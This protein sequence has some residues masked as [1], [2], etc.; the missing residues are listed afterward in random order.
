MAQIGS[1][2][3]TFTASV[4]GLTAGV[5]AAGK[6]FKAL[7]GD[8]AT[9]RSSLSALSNLGKQGFLEVGP[10]A[11][12]ASAAFAQI[13]GDVARLRAEFVSG[14]ISAGQFA[15][16]MTALTA[17]AK[18]MATATA[19]AAAITRENATATQTYLAAIDRITNAVKNGGLAEDVAARAR[20][21]ALDTFMGAAESADVET[22]A[23]DRLNASLGRLGDTAAENPFAGISEAFAAAIE[24]SDAINAATKDVEASLA[25]QAA[26]SEAAAI[27]E[28]IRQEQL[29]RGAEIAA[30]VASATQLHADALDEL[31]VLQNAGA[32]SAEVYAAAVARQNEILAE[33]DGSAQAARNAADELADAHQR[34]AAVTRANM[35][36]QERYAAEV[37]DLNALLRVGAI[38][39][40]TYNRAVSEAAGRMRTAGSAAETMS[41]GLS[42][43]SSRLNVLIGL[44]V[45]RI[46]ASIATSVSNAV[47]SLVRM[48]QAEAGVIDQTSKLAAR[49]GI[50]YG[51]MAGLSLAAE[52]AG[53]GVES[54]RDAMTKADVTF[55]NAANGSQQA[56]QAF[57]RIGLSAQQ[58]N[59][60]NTAD[61]FQAIA[62][63]IAALPTE[64][65]RA[66]AAVQIFGRSGADLLPLFEG[67]AQGIAAARREAEQLGLALTTA[68]GQDVQRLV[69]AFETA[70]NAIQGVVQQVVAYLA[71]A[72]T[73]VVEQFNQFIASVGGAN[74]GQA[75]GEGILDGAEYLAGV[76][77]WLVT[78][79]TSVWQ[80]VA[81]VGGSW[82]QTI[83]FM[84][85][86]A[87]VFRALFDAA[88]V[89]FLGIVRIAI[90]PFS[91]II[92]QLANLA[93][94]LPGV[95]GEVAAQVSAA[96]AGFRDGIDAQIV[97]FAK[98]AASNLDF[99][100]NG[101]AAQAG[102]QLAGPLV[103]ALRE[104]R[105][106][107][108]ASATAIEAAKAQPIPIKQDV[109]VKVT[110]AAG[111]AQALKGI[112][113]RSSEGVA[114]MFRLMRGDT[115]NVQERQLEAL[116]TIADNTS[117]METIPAMALTGA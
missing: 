98:D 9:L 47:G 43:I 16:S 106:T 57:Q 82:N 10:A 101:T 62:Q 5:E 22:A 25:Q 37:S 1:I 12:A 13:S 71:P 87:A 23:L 85:Q 112:D 60:L 44:D 64:A 68:Q 31:G 102:Q 7:G 108:R 48:G 81:S 65:E 29:A 50:T 32:I 89:L 2:N 21:A 105:A 41:S 91:N 73:G 42:G 113:S 92:E 110:E 58:L 59:G 83:T 61:R 75:I 19:D 99:A 52:K 80:Y 30:S 46:F 67:G 54:M 79:L 109:A 3:A 6:A 78:N 104:A 116:Q 17:Q 77:D 56:V 111:I 15:I 14:A 86:V 63:A 100:T 96:T 97:G 53:V 24:S 107:S 39:Q 40:E 114:E 76:G 94:Y 51:E 70:Q 20:Q 45:A 11:T 74:I 117:G 90:T 4:G 35:T 33:A 69:S 95:A 18:Q 36:A 26:A 34:G 38:S 55:V 84:Q 8:T 93:S 27:A 72:I 49:I 28:E 115:G 103:T 66:A 88:A